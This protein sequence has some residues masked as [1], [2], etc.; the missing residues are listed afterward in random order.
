MDLETYNKIT[1]ICKKTIVRNLHNKH[2]EDCIQYVAMEYFRRQGGNIKWMI[3][4]Y[5]RI[6]GIGKK[7]YLRNKV[8]ETSLSLDA[9]SSEENENSEY[10]LH[11]ESIL[12]CEQEEKQNNVKDYAIGAL[13]EFLSP[14]ILNKGVLRWAIKNYKLDK[15]KVKKVT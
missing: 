9:P 13:E 4:D 7:G 1:A 10:F 5:L 8:L 11:Q 3:F 6:E 12:R 15:T 14:I 2:L